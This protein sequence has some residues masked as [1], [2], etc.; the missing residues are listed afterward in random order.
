M[1]EQE[2][3]IRYLQQQLTRERQRREMLEAELDQARWA[4]QAAQRAKTA[5]VANLN[6]E[7]HT[8]LNAIIGFT[9]VLQD[10]VSNEDFSRAENDLTKIKQAGVQLLSMINELL[11]LARLES[12]SMTLR[13]ENF[14]L[15]QEVERAVAHVRP[16]LN[17]QNNTLEVE[18]APELAGLNVLYGD[19]AKV[20][21]ILGHLLENA[22][23]FTVEG[24][25]RVVATAVSCA[26]I[27]A[28]QIAVT[29]TGIGLDPEHQDMI[30]DTFTQVD[31]SSTRHYEGVGLGL[32]IS[33][34]LAELM[35]GEIGVESELGVGSTFYFCFPRQLSAENTT[36]VQVQLNTAV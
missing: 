33:K 19:G 4:A 18:I 30:F 9:E 21:Q 26:G 31:P 3:T 28:V 25:V 29:D 14:S 36:A 22:A 32:Y 15:P 11:D 10:D 6:H 20:R 17:G 16:F 35:G 27:P 8:P 2:A 13:L 5:F 7:L 1:T 24:E 34:R 12:N 23:K